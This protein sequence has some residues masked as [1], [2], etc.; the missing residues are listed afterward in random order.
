MQVQ[1][2]VAPTEAA[3]A[4]YLATTKQTMQTF[5]ANYDAVQARKEGAGL[6]QRGQTLPFRSTLACTT[7]SHASATAARSSKP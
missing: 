1:T 4:S 5:L 7:S 2:V 6:G 3:I